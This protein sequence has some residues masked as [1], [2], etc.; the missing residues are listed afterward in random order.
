MGKPGNNLSFV[1]VPVKLG[2]ET[3]YSEVDISRTGATVDLG[4]TLGNVV[5][6]IQAVTSASSLGTTASTHATS[7]PLRRNRC[8][9]RLRVLL[10][11]I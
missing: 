5:S 6:G 8:T 9:A 4:S 2:V 11:P 1:R 10:V 7:S 3:G